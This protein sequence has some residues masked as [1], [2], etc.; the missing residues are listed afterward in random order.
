[1][2]SV[3]QCSR[4]LDRLCGEAEFIVF[5]DNEKIVNA[6]FVS[7]A[8]VR[9]FEKLVLGKNPVFAIEAVM[10]ICGICHASHGIAAAEAF[11]NALGI[12]PPPE[13][14]R[15]REVIGL[16]NRIQSHLYHLLLMIPD[17]VGREKS[18]AY[19]LDVIHVLNNVNDILIRVGGAPTHPPNI[20]IGGVLKPPTEA[21]LKEC[22]RKLG[23]V[24]EKYLELKN[25]LEELYSDNKY[26]EELQKHF[27]P[28]DVL[29]LASH[30]FYG[31][32]YNIEP[33]KVRIVRYEEYRRNNRVNM[34]DK[35]LPLTTTQIALYDD[36]IVETGPHSRLTLY[37]GYEGSSLWDLQLTRL[38]EIELAIDRIEELLENIRLSAPFKTSVVYRYGRGIGVFEA[39]RGTL[40]HYVE[41][42]DDGRITNYVIVVPT[43]FNI[44]VI[45]RVA[46]GVSIEI[47]DMIPRIF[48][49]CVPC[50]TH[51]VRIE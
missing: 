13:G 46:E 26:V 11:E 47:A 31:D 28:N 21:S 38:E 20:I 16:L 2:K 10:R 23:I 6:Y 22:F 1:M 43:M 5:H 48:D 40:F 24:R 33:S 8:P 34:E 37:R 7:K 35:E 4:E 41:L 32:R 14:R 29:K 44:P 50:T 51:Y 45:E 9:G 42:N 18:S 36:K 19:I 15:L 30:L 25:K 17:I 27:L 12:M 49:P 3:K 39:P